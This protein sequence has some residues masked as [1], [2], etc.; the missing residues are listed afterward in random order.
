MPT[1]RSCSAPSTASSSPST[2]LTGK[3]V[4]VVKHAWPEK[5]ETITNAPLIAENLVIIGFGGDEFA[6]R[7]RVNAYDLKTGKEV[8]K[9][10]STGSDKDVCLT[11][12]TNKANPHY[13]TAGTDLGIKTHVGE[14]YKIGGGSA[15]GWFSYDP[16]LKM[17]YY[18]T[19]NPGLWS[20]AY[21]CSKKTHEECNT[22]EFDNKW[23]MTIFARKVDTGEAV[24]AYQMTPFDQWDYDGVNENILVDM[25]IDG[26]KRQSADA[27]RPQ[28]LR[29]RHRP[30]R[31]AR[32]CA[33]TSTSRSI[34]PRRST[35]RPAVP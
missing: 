24:W 32:F 12:D 34:G 22:G 2:L 11:A 19:G 15:W 17:V 9:C 35:S 18:S 14:D 7:G 16:E 20:P 6:A 21:R 23:S 31:T 29:L 26:K 4:W 33:P 27:L 5:G 25:D 13:G 3:E 8:W 28:R 10:Y 30:H 1:A